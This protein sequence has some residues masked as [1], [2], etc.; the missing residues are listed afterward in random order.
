VLGTYLRDARESAGISRADAARTIRGSTSKISRMETA[1]SPQFPH[2]VEDLLEYYGK[3]SP[4]DIPQILALAERALKAEWWQPY[5]PVIRD[6]VQL[7]LGLESD[8]HTIRTY[9]PH[10]IPGLLQTEEYARALAVTSRYLRSAD[11]V[12]KMVQLRKKRQERLLKIGGPRMWMMLDESVLRR[13]VGGPAVMR[14]QLEHL[15]QVMKGQAVV[16]VAQ[17]HAVAQVTPGSAVTY[18]RFASS[19]L[20]D[21]VY[22]EMMNNGIYHL[23]ND[24]AVEDYRA[25]LDQLSA[26]AETPEASETF[27]AQ[28]LEH[29]Q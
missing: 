1:T 8:A 18:L 29:S 22:V 25:T 20:P 21:M 10:F 17:L 19:F 13:P 15:L 12:E 7:L 9:E 16:Q 14:R 6:W 4:E 2:D 3:T 24:Q 26:L 27:I 5:S 23:D 28:M 11:D